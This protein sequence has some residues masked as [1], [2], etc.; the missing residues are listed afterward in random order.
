MFNSLHS[1]H[2]FTTLTF[3][4]ELTSYDLSPEDCQVLGRLLSTSKSL[5]KLD[6]VSCSFVDPGI[7]YISNGLKQSTLHHLNIS[8][9]DID[10]NGAHLIAD[11]LCCN[12]TLGGL[13]M[14]W[15]SI[16]DDGAKALAQMLVRNQTLKYLDLYVC[17]ITELGA[18]KLAEALC[19]NSALTK[20]DLNNNAIKD[21]GAIALAQMLTRNQSLSVLD[22]R[23][24]SISGVGAS[25]LARS[26]L[27]NHTIT[28]VRLVGNNI[29][30]PP[31]SDVPIDP[32]LHLL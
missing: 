2:S 14:S 26:L 31:H 23:C 5:T 21:Q 11:A 16:G 27:T 12:N 17:D 28:D 9:C 20:I 15:N 3:F 1:L 25:H 7:E 24:C 13:G 29:I 30:P 10:S 22:V 6:I 18:I 4:N 8:V 19:I 32:R